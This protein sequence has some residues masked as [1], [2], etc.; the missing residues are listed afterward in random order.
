M[1]ERGRQLRQAE[2]QNFRLS[3]FHEKNIRGLDVAM[4][5]SLRVRR[6]EAVGD[7][8][9]DLQELRNFDGLSV[10]AVFERLALEQLHGDERTAFEFADIVNG[11]DVGMIERGRGARFAAETLDGL[12]VLGDVVGKE[13]QRD[14]A[15][16]A[17][18][19]GFVDHAHSAAAQFFQDAVV[20]DG[21]AD[22]GGSIR[23][24][25]SILRQRV[26][27]RN[28]ATSAIRPDKRASPRSGR[29][30]H[31]N[32]TRGRM[33]FGL[34]PVLQKT[35]VSIV[36]FVEPFQRPAGPRSKPILGFIRQ[37][38]G[39]AF[40]VCLIPGNGTARFEGKPRTHAL[41]VSLVRSRP[42]RE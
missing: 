1:S 9:A 2:I 32:S 25:P 35:Y 28:R 33:T 41:R 8:N 14:T 7:L 37:G 17:R 30:L 21:A 31:F 34:S 20:G 22:N 40:P 23:H 39:C 6:V 3:A 36:D 4:H 26:N 29:S 27:T 16:E 18:V 12:S 10:D 24:R 38:L 15:A 5:D 13:F 19:L 11:A 42:H